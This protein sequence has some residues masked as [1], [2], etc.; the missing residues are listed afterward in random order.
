MPKGPLIQDPEKRRLA[1]ALIMGVLLTVSL[2]AAILISG[3]D[4]GL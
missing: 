3:A 2:A 1:I 4:L